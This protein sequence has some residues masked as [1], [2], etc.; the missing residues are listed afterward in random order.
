MKINDLY[1]HSLQIELLIWNNVQKK[2]KRT[3]KPTLYL[4][5]ANPWNDDNVE[6][7]ALMG[8]IIDFASQYKSK[9][10]QTIKICI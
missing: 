9:V 1:E 4:I 2:K 3:F 8:E 5:F 6:N 10:V 7:L